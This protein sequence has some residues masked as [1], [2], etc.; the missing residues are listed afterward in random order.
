MLGLLK[1]D[2]VRETAISFLGSGPL[3][4]SAATLDGGSDCSRA[5]HGTGTAS[6]NGLAGV[7]LQG[8]L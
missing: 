4:I 6:L 1:F 3:I 8:G 5:G 7:G 2:R